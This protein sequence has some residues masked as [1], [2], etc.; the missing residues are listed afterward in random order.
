MNL[1]EAFL[2]SKLFG[3]SG[4]GGGSASNDFSISKMTISSVDGMTVNIFAPTVLQ[5]Q[6]DG[7]L[8]KIVQTMTDIDEE[9]T[10]FDLIGINP[11]SEYYMGISGTFFL[12]SNGSPIPDDKVTVTGN[13]TYE[14]QQGNFTGG[15]FTVVVNLN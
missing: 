2:A 1:R 7:Q 6:L 10:Q 13:A 4:G 9:E 12:L 11:D 3:N 15:D 14:N 8:K 5:G